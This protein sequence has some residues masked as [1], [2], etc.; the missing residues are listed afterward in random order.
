MNPTASFA[1]SPVELILSIPDNQGK[2]FPVGESIPLQFTFRNTSDSPLCIVKPLDGSLWGYRYPK[3]ECIAHPPVPL[4]EEHPRM[5]CGTLNPLFE[6][7]FVRI[8]PNQ[9]CSL[10]SEFYIGY[11]PMMAGRHEI[12]YAIDFNGPWE[13]YSWEY[14]NYPNITT[15]K[16][17]WEQVPKIKIQSAT[18][19]IDVVSNGLTY[20]PACHCLMGMP[21]S[22]VKRM[23]NNTYPQ[24][25]TPYLLAINVL[26]YF[27]Y[28]AFL[29]DIHYD[30]ENIVDG[31]ELLNHYSGTSQ[32]ELSYLLPLRGKTK[33]F[34][35]TIE[36]KDG[37]IN[38]I[39]IGYFA[40]QSNV[41]N[42]LFQDYR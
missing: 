11:Q 34:P 31:V 17:L 9:T 39:R 21:D 7:D 12:S 1:Q 40:L 5:E 41:I 15:L 16:A 28:P 35:E 22:E 23:F 18:V 42:A 19:G 36:Y 29:L 13:S 26:N 3:Y 20:D 27:P 37:Y 32:I 25:N 6:S 33:A 8:E 4:Y 24:G 30:A 38:A 14:K 2:P 10:S